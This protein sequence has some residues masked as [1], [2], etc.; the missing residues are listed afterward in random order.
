MTHTIR[1]ALIVL[2][3]F[4]WTGIAESFQAPAPRFAATDKFEVVSSRTVRP[5]VTYSFIVDKRG[6]WRAHVL[7]ID[8]RHAEL[9]ILAA[10]ALDKLFGREATTSIAKRHETN[11]RTMIAA[12]NADFFDLT[13]GENENNNVIDAEYA[14][15]TKMTGSPF[16]TFDNIH[17]Q[18]ALS[19]GRKP[20]LDRFEF[21]GK[22]FW[23][24]SNA[25]DLHGINDIP[26][27]NSMVLFNHYYGSSSP[28]DTLKMDIQE[29]SL[30]EIRKNQDTSLAIVAA[31][32]TSGGSTIGAGMFVL[33]GYDL[34]KPNMIS[35]AN[36]G[37]TV[38]I[39]IGT[40]PN[41]G[42][43][44]TLVGGWPRIVLDGNNIG[45][46]VDALEG[47]FPTF[48]AK[49]NPRSG[50]GFSIDSTTV[51]FIAVDGRQQ[52]SAGMT[53]TEFADLMIF[54]GVYQGLNL[55]GGGSTT[56]VLEGKIMNTPSDATGERPV[57]NC[58]LLYTPR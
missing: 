53:L 21:V 17:S 9:E 37:D 20:L 48:S 36:I 6:P 57:G 10:R 52:S 13:T 18:F 28:T 51:Y 38:R 2:L 22:V 29:L 54:Q 39:W 25:S 11:D 15:G 27:S 7:E 4:V 45:A 42:T 56:F 14:K 47:T 12:L 23:N 50:V 24:Q 16:D 5:G 34:A 32:A 33:S 40:N 41:R 3:V 1:V 58:L 31:K 49:R 35:L 26:K 46:S 44:K 43:L 8:L 30:R 19:I 55:D